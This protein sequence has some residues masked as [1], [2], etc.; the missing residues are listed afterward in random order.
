MGRDRLLRRSF[1]ASPHAAVLQLTP[2]TASS[3]VSA[4]SRRSTLFLAR[5]W[6][7]FSGPCGSLVIPCLQSTSRLS[8][9]VSHVATDG[10]AVRSQTASAGLRCGQ[11][12]WSGSRDGSKNAVK[13]GLTAPPNLWALGG[14]HLADYWHVYKIG[15]QS[16]GISLHEMYD[17]AF[18][19]FTSFYAG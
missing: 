19:R 8:G 12:R 2:S 5:M 1:W 7:G 13:L 4:T 18:V 15:S 11:G 10:S 17:I 14:A 6:H 16:I 3:R 9:M